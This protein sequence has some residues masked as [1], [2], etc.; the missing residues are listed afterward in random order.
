MQWYLRFKH[1][2]FLLA[3]FLL[4]LYWNVVL[5]KARATGFILRC[6]VPPLISPRSVS[7]FSCYCNNVTPCVSAATHYVCKTMIHEWVQRI[8]SCF[9]IHLSLFRAEAFL[10]CCFAST[11]LRCCT[12]LRGIIF[13]RR[14]MDLAIALLIILIDPNEIIRACNAFPTD[15]EIYRHM[16][17]THVSN[18]LAWVQ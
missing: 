12:D 5:S 4:L 11:C 13:L 6:F 17:E 18:F 10:I 1:R 9:V 15:C 2:P 14:S 3:S 7:L 8:A 16:S